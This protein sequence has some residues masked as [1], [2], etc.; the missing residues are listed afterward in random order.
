M[1]HLKW[2]I[3]S[4][5]LDKARFLFAAHFAGWNLYIIR[6]FQCYKEKAADNNVP[7]KHNSGLYD[8]LEVYRWFNFHTIICIWKKSLKLR[9]KEWENEE[10]KHSVL[11]GWS[12]AESHK[13]T[14]RWFS[15]VGADLQRTTQ[16]ASFSTCHSGPWREKRWQFRIIIHIQLIIKFTTC[17]PTA[18][19]RRLGK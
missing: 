4:L 11:T 9:L 18:A 6:H 7:D 12:S 5:I 10:Q 8:F 3:G 2:Y 19:V 1:Y 17:G 13:G 16:R 15:P 14:A